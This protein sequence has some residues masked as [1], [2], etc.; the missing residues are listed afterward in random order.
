MFCGSEV[1]T[2]ALPPGRSLAAARSGQR[3]TG[4]TWSPARWE[5]PRWAGSRGRAGSDHNVAG[6]RQAGTGQAG[7]GPGQ[8]LTPSSV[9]LVISAW[10]S[11]TVNARPSHNRAVAGTQVGGFPDVHEPAK[12]GA[13]A[14]ADRHA[15]AGQ[16]GPGAG[17]GPGPGGILS[18]VATPCPVFIAGRSSLATSPPPQTAVTV[19]PAS[20]RSVPSTSSAPGPAPVSGSQPRNPQE[21]RAGAVQ[22][23][24]EPGQTAGSDTSHPLTNTVC[25]VKNA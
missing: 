10:E 8:V 16:G 3:G 25:N 14:A 6:E 21:R 24:V 4:W 5:Q 23:G 17:A 9:Q 7:P 12:L 18:T 22:V 20:T 1:L 19:V 2:S 11:A 13:S 15:G